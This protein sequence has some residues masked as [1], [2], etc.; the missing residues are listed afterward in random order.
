[1]DGCLGIL[2]KYKGQI[3]CNSRGGFDN[4]VTDSIKQLMSKYTCLDEVL[5]QNILICEV[6]CP[7]TKIIC[8]Y[9]NTK[10]LYL[11]TS[12]NTKTMEENAMARNHFLSSFTGIPQVKSVE[13]TWEELFSWQKTAGWDKEGFVLSFIDGDNV[14]RVKIKSDE[15]LKI[16]KFKAGLSPEAIDSLIALTVIS[17][18]LYSGAI[19]SVKSG[20]PIQFLAWQVTTVSSSEITAAIAVHVELLPTLTI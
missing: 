11:I 6:I 3:R 9:G 16:A 17:S 13:M 15:Y 18:C 5:E 12:Y 14:E 2:Y 7:A 4:Y 20:F 10:D 8:D 19:I 1:M